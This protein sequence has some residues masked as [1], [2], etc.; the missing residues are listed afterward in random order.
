MLDPFPRLIKPKLLPRP[1]TLLQ[2]TTNL[3]RLHSARELK[4]QRLIIQTAL[5]ELIR[6]DHKRLLEAAIIVRRDLA[7]NARRLAQLHQIHDRIR[8]NADL[9][10]GANDFRHV[11]LTGRHHAGRVKTRDLA[12]PEL[13]DADAV[14]DVAVLAQ[15]RLHGGD[16]EGSDRLDDRVLAEEP[17]G[18]V[19]VVDVAVDEDA[20]AELGVGDEEAGRVQLVAGLRA[21]D[22]G[23]ADRACVASAPGVAVGGVEAAGEAAE[24][25]EVRFCFRGVDDG[26]GLWGFW[27]AG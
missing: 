25:F 22:G 2:R 24:D 20:A 11:V 17:Q 8:I 10:L 21:E 12:A 1:Q 27:S 13:D 4:R 19:D 16:A 18:Q 3:D 9:P 5:G 14:V 6:L 15:V 7:P 23:A 26:L